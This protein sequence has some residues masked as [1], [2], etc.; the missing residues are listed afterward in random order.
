MTMMQKSWRRCRQWVANEEITFPICSSDKEFV[1]DEKSEEEEEEDGD[2]NAI[3]FK[4]FP[5]SNDV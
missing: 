2:E 4:Y 1:A 5:P 3:F